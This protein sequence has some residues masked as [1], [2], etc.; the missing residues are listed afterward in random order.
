MAPAGRDRLRSG[1]QRAKVLRAGD[2]R[3]GGGRRKQGNYE[4]LELNLG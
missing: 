2:C 4:N 1:L 3:R